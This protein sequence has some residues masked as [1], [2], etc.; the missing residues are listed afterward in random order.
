MC[1]ILDSDPWIVKTRN[2]LDIEETNCSCGIGRLWENRKN[3][4]KPLVSANLFSIEDPLSFTIPTRH[5]KSLDQLQMCSRSNFHYSLSNIRGQTGVGNNRHI[6]RSQFYK[7]EPTLKN[8]ASEHNMRNRKYFLHDDV[9]TKLNSTK[10]NICNCSLNNYFAVTT[11][12]K[13]KNNGTIGKFDMSLDLNMVTEK[14]YKQFNIKNFTNVK[15]QYNTLVKSMSQTPT[16]S[17]QNIFRSNSVQFLS[18]K[19][20][21]SNGFN[22]LN[23]L[24]TKKGNSRKSE[25]LIE[26]GAQ[27]KTTAKTPEAEQDY[28][29]RKSKSKKHLSNSKQFEIGS[30]SSSTESTSVEKLTGSKCEALLSSSGLRKV[31]ST[32]CLVEEFFPLILSGTESLPNITSKLEERL[33]PEMKYFSSSTSSTTSEQSGWITSR[34]S[35]IGKFQLAG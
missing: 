22:K 11:N 26:N 1:I 8:V 23:L 18:P 3:P 32:S 10:E 27:I 33:Y 19:K 35:S 9:K 13:P 31:R 14:K 24:L 6:E 5:S 4:E 25:K 34:S 28:C 17:T 2:R 29:T 20:R 21:V 15:Q 16:D 30:T 7:T 12:K